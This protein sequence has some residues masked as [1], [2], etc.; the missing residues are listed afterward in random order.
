[1]RTKII[2]AVIS[3]GLAFC[4]N[5]RSWAIG[6]QGR[7]EQRFEDDF[8]ESLKKLVLTSQLSNV[9][10][11]FFLLPNRGDALHSDSYLYSRIKLIRSGELIGCPEAAGV[12][13]QLF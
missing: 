5:G 4:G 8:D 7:A 12:L 11:I 3:A 10:D 9:R 6:P 2:P 1:M 13:K